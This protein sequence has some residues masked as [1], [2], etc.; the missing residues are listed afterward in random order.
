M[1][2]NDL[3][4]VISASP[5]K[6][7]SQSVIGRGRPSG[8]E[9]SLIADGQSVVSSA[10]SILDS[11]SSIF[12][13]RP[14]APAAPSDRGEKGSTQDYQ[15][16][17][18]GQPVVEEIPDDDDIEEKI[19]DYLIFRNFLK[20]STQ[21]STDPLLLRK[22]TRKYADILQICGNLRVKVF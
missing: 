19:R 10:S 14:G 6:T 8:G 7:M 3:K 5:R 20:S 21:G 16:G 1:V 13:I 11:I 4:S 18:F 15:S 9:Q 22:M 17:N 12:S 2:T